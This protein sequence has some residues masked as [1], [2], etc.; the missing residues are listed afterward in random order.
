MVGMAR[1]VE[2]EMCLSNILANGNAI[3]RARVCLIVCSEKSANHY[4]QYVLCSAEFAGNVF[5]IDS[6]GLWQHVARNGESI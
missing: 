2:I 5:C 4:V 6:N 1:K 3:E